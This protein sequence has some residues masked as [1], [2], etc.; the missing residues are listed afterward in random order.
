MVKKTNIFKQATHAAGHHHKR[1]VKGVRS[2][3]GKRPIITLLGTAFVAIIL[4]IGLFQVP[5]VASLC[6]NIVSKDDSTEPAKKDLTDKVET[7]AVTPS[8]SPSEDPI[9]AEAKEIDKK[10]VGGVVTPTPACRGA[11]CPTANPKFSIITQKSFTV[12]DGSSI[13][14]FTAST[15][16]GSSVDWSGPTYVSGIGPY[17]YGLT[18][19]FK[20][21]TFEYYIRAEAN[22]PPGVYTCVMSVIQPS[23][24]SIVKT[25]V[26]VTV[27]AGPDPMHGPM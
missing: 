12:Y 15:S 4:V 23:T 11:G 1:A 13:G 2:Y 17:S 18:G 25:T 3:Y 24:E 14:P 26:D 5:G 6:A 27:L 22:V 21:P 7:L 8:P 16:N 19:S 20:G 9:E 10:G